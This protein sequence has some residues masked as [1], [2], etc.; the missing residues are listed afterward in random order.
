MKDYKS[1]LQTARA[2]PYKDPITG[3]PIGFKV[4]RLLPGSLF[5]ELGI[6]RGDVIKNVNGEPVNSINKALEVFAN[7][8]SSVNNLNNVNLIVERNGSEKKFNYNVE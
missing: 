1:L 4:I 5:E 2:I 7:I 8:K 3:E 6:Q